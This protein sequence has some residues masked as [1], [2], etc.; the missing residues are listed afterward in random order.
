MPGYNPK[1]DPEFQAGAVE[2]RQHMQNSNPDW[3]V[4][5][6]GGGD[7]GGGGKG[8]SVIAAA[9]ITGAGIAAAYLGHKYGAA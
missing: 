3:G 4:Y 5:N 2:L 9:L 7:N 1:N 6:E 8:C